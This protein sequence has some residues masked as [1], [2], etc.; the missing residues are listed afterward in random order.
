MGSSRGRM[1]FLQVS[2]RFESPYMEP[3]GIDVGAVNDN[4]CESEPKRENE[5]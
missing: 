5:C 2:E 4:E 3:R 1:G